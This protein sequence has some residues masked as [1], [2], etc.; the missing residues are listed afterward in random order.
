[1]T[2]HLC[3]AE[4]C[5]LKGGLALARFMQTA[6][7]ISWNE[8]T[9]DGQLTLRPVDCL[10]MCKSAPCA[11]ADGRTFVKLTPAKLQTTVERLG[12]PKRVPDVSSTP[13][14]DV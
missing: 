6:Y 5:T 13:P 7:G 9:R 10:G 2:L 3:R 14:R 1:M 8:T 12:G 4:N 11:A